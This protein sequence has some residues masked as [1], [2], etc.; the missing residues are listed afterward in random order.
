MTLRSYVAVIRKNWL[1][2][3]LASLLGSS[4]GA[5]AF[6]VTPP[7]YA[8]SVDFYVSTP[9]TQGTSAQ[10][11]GQFAESRVNSYILLLS[12]EQMA[13]RVIE[14]TDVDLSPSELAD[15]V[16]ASAELNTVVVTATVT[17]SSAERAARI[18]EGLSEEFPTLV[19][20]LDNQG[21][22]ADAIV[23]INVV[24][25]PTAPVQVA[26][27]WRKNIGLGLLAGLAAGLLIAVLRELLDT[28]V[29]QA[30]VAQQLVGAPV[31][32][33]IG[34]DSDVKKAPLIIEGG[35]KST[36]AEAYRQ[37][38]TNLQFIVA[39]RPA[40]VIVVT[41]SVPL[42]GKSTTAAN[43]GLT[44]AQFGERVLLVEG[45]LRRPELANY[46]G[47][48]R[49]VGLTNVLA[50]QVELADVIQPWGTGGLFLLAS[51]STPPNPSE[52]LGSARMREVIANLRQQ[53]DKIVIDTPPIL[54][55][56]D[57][58]VASS[59]A[60]AVL[61]VIRHGHTNRAQLATASQALVNVD[62]P[63]VGCVLNMRKSSRADRRVYGPDNYYGRNE[64]RHGGVAV[65]TSTPAASVGRTGPF[66][67]SG[68]DR[69]AE[70]RRDVGV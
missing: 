4:L 46:L 61:L 32:G 47:L 40:D 2:L 37:L 16:G 11:G 27:D 68:P 45:D 17:D 50:G 63:V 28:S 29:R 49:E 60:D 20:E 51:G 52:L 67:G 35:L 64:D 1:I 12:S 10:A 3:V 48:E 30:E 15:K 6:W 55:V 14:S 53:F 18:T 23:V 22:T 44:F 31:V 38:R 66:S 69:S 8:S 34:F 59:W 7:R 41:S 56:T 57:A 36:R 26:P 13:R 25:G 24:S 33:T 19:D 21:R 65:S 43:L 58:A 54:P 39:A 5:V 42:E 62:A 70:S 9:R